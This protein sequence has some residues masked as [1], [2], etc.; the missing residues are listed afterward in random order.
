MF[1][2]GDSLVTSR[3]KR[4]MAESVFVERERN[5][6]RFDDVFWVM[7]DIT[8]ARTAAFTGNQI[9][10]ALIRLWIHC[11]SSASWEPDIAGQLILLAFR[12]E[13]RPHK[14]GEDDRF[15]LLL[16]CCRVGAGFLGRD[17]RCG[18]SPRLFFILASS[19]PSVQSFHLFLKRV[20]PLT[21]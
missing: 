21:G 5:I 19:C 1:W 17:A 8:G 20:L 4:D 15:F 3:V 13:M 14:A 10:F 11:G 6:G 18:L 12:Y 9:V 7:T 2:H 16:R